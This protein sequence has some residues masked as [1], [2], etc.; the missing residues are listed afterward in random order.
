MVTNKRS[1]CKFILEGTHFPITPIF[2]F[3]TLL[4]S[5]AR[6]PPGFISG[7]LT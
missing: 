7:S 2:S 5:L 1:E 6:I 4:F 3:V